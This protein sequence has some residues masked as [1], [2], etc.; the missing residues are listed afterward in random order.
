MKLCVVGHGKSLEGASGGRLID[1]C[2]AVIRFK[3]G[4]R[5]SFENPKDYGT[6]CDYL[7]A[8]TEVPGCFLVPDE[9]KEKIEAFIA[10]PK[11]G[12][13]NEHAVESIEAALKREIHVPLNLTNLWNYQFRRM[14]GSHPN[15]SVGMAG[16]VILAHELRPKQVLLAGMDALLNPTGEFRRIDSVPRTGTGDFPA[17]DWATEH[18]LLQHIAHEYAFTYEDILRPLYELSEQHLQ[19]SG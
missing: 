4:W 11:L 1:E 5:I 13:Y 7:V 10:Y 17:H 19:R 18:K 9:L 6:K 15:F 16:I 3:K 2:D 12:F 8:S 14:G